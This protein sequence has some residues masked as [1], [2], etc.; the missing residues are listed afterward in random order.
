VILQDR[1]SCLLF[2]E[3]TMTFLH[4][5]LNIIPKEGLKYAFSYLIKILD[6]LFKYKDNQPLYTDMTRSIRKLKEK[7][8]IELV[9]GKTPRQIIEEFENTCRVRAKSKQQDEEE[10]ATA[11]PE[12]QNAEDENQNEQDK[13]TPG[14][15]TK[16]GEKKEEEEKTD[17]GQDQIDSKKEKKIVRENLLNE[18]DT[19]NVYEKDIHFW[20][21]KV[22]RYIAYSIDGGLLQSKFTLAKMIK[23]ME[24]VTDTGTG[25]E[26]RGELAYM[27]HCRK[28]NKEYKHDDIYKFLRE[29]KDSYGSFQMNQKVLVVLIES[30]HCQ[31]QLNL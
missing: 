17:K 22:A 29:I 27:L 7:Y 23:M 13:E 31:Q 1:A 11:L 9:V 3:D 5:N 12:E 18:D 16:E 20:K 19:Q 4:Y 21:S 8:G 24:C 28:K 6:M 15:E 14:E 26:L 10:E 30:Q 2:D 25:A